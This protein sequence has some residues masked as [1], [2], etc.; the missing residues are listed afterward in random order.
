[1]SLTQSH[2]NAIPRTGEA[3]TT[4]T[5]EKRDLLL[6][7]RFGWHHS[8]GEDTRNEKEGL[9]EE[10][11]H[12]SLTKKTLSLLLIAQ[13]AAHL[14]WT[15]TWRLAYAVAA[16]Y[17]YS[18]YCK[19]LHTCPRCFATSLARPAICIARPQVIHL[20]YR[21][22]QLNI[23]ITSVL[24][25]DFFTGKILDSFFRTVAFVSLDSSGEL[26]VLTCHPKQPYRSS[27]KH[28]GRFEE[29]H[30]CKAPS[31]RSGHTH[32]SVSWQQSGSSVC[33]HLQSCSA[34]RLG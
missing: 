34:S 2:G 23:A 28:Q 7:Q 20:A 17:S 19:M 22:D 26:A 1:M 11:V 21:Y 3:A 4:L 5:R 25:C 13:S 29:R 9:I 6:V 8:Q 15:N 16:R 31:Y 18:T 32:I 30:L 12:A 24:R 10:V 27:A 14:P 33:S